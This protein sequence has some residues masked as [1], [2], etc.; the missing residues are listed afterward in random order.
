[1]GNVGFFLDINFFPKAIL[2]VGFLK[3]KTIYANSNIFPGKGFVIPFNSI[4]NKIADN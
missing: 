1:M 3:N 2:S 4:F